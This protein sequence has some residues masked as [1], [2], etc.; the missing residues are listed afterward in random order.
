LLTPEPNFY[1]LG[2]KRAAVDA[3]FRF[4]QGLDQIRALF[5]IIGDRAE[6]NLY[7]SIRGLPGAS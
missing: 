3:E 4:I 5:A 6:L 2:S 7:E 1:F